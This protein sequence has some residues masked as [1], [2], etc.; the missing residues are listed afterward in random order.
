MRV[1]M[2]E[3]YH[4]IGY[5]GSFLIAISL[6]M[7]NIR[8]LRQINLFGAST[9]ATYGFLI[10]SYPVLA[11]N[12]YIAAIDLFFLFKMYAT[13][14][15]FSMIP[16]LD[17]SHL[18]LSKFIEFYQEDIRKFFPEFDKSKL[19]EFNCFFILRDLRPVGLFI[20]KQVSES[21]I[22][23]E[24]DYAIPE[25]RDLKNGKYVYSVE[26][27]YLEEKGY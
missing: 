24:L 22:K 2:Y 8:R 4:M 19:P 14:E 18:Y 27:K 6:S 9:F 15:Q 25:Y 11:L 13:K 10:G 23:I 5:A 21:E 26:A 12:S 3:Y 16:V 17:S 1:E 20:F 7:K